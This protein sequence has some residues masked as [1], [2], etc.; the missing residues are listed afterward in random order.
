MLGYTF[1][2]VSLE[3]RIKQQKGGYM[4]NEIIA[5]VVGS[6]WFKEWHS[7]RIEATRMAIA[8]A[9]EVLLGSP[10]MASCDRNARIEVMSEGV[11]LIHEVQKDP[12][13][14]FE[15]TREQAKDAYLRFGD[16]FVGVYYM[17]QSMNCSAQTAFQCASALFRFFEMEDSVLIPDEE[18]GV[19]S[20]ANCSIEYFEV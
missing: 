10:S 6:P 20:S 19:Y 4:K 5:G 8:N 16:T 1:F 18:D 11:K 15:C 3:R 9:R 2:Q 12:L 14:G 7:Q 17:H 13:Y